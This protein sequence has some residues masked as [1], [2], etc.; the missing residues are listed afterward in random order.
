MKWNNK[1]STALKFAMLIAFATA[2]GTSCV[3]PKDCDLLTEKQ[4]QKLRDGVAGAKM[5]K[6]FGH[7]DVSF[8]PLP[9][10]CLK[11]ELPKLEN[12]DSYWFGQVIDIE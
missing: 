6:Q 11:S 5:V 9:C 10:K 12:D 4:K 1:F 8:P 3:Q 2:L 7:C